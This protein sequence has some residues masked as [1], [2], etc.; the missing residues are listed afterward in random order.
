VLTEEWGI[1]FCSDKTLEDL[2]PRTE[3]PGPIADYWF[4]HDQ[5]A[6]AL[7]RNAIAS[8]DQ[9]TAILHNALADPAVLGPVTSSRR[10]LILDG[11]AL[12]I[13]L[14]ERLGLNGPVL[15][16]G[17]HAGFVTQSLA[18]ELGRD[19]VG[20]DPSTRAVEEGRRRLT[21]EP[22]LR[23]LVGGIPWD[24]AERFELVLAIDSMPD[25]PTEM[26]QFL[27][28]I[29]AVLSPGGIA[30][31][32]SMHWIGA[33]VERLRVHLKAAQLGFAYADVVGGYMGLPPSFETEGVVV[34]I[35]GGNQKYPNILVA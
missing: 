10:A 31:V 28:G 11:I 15:D 4:A 35:K 34:F 2:L 8:V 23:L 19:T 16:V 13:G 25:E 3:I 27:R 32:V 29:G 5:V 12:A 30:I 17:C 22:N 6:E 26:G 7:K 18:R 20:I 9:L 24:T 21:V 33:T 1:A 14:A